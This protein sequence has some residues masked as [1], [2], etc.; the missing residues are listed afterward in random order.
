MIKKVIA[1]VVLVSLLTVAIVQ[2]MDKKTDTPKTATEASAAKEGLSIGASAPDFELKTLTGD[3]VKLSQ[4]KGKKV[5]LNF[6]AT[7]CPPCKAE[8]PEME[9][10]SKQIG[11]DT[12]ILAVN[13]DP[14]LDVQGFVNENKITFPILLDAEDKVNEAY[15]ILSIPTTYFINSKGIIQNKYTGSMKL[16]VMK[17]YT[18]ELN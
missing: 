7:W 9:Q 2:A 14:Q 15:Q 17:K 3:T 11:D 6:W 4:L 10:F 5:M 1:A 12:V 8:M 13:I 18:Q 16:D